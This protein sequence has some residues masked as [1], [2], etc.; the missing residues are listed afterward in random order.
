M[1]DAGEVILGFD[2]VAVVKAYF[3][4]PPE[5]IFGKPVPVS[6]DQARFMNIPSGCVY[7]SVALPTTKSVTQCGFF[8]H[9]R[10]LV[11]G[12]G[13]IRKPPKQKAH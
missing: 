9:K 7:L 1:A 11:D 3:S 10:G 6:K 12:R 2:P 4:F 5:T 13:S 8:V